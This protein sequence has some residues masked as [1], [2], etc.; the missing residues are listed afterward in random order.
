LRAELHEGDCLD[1]LP[2]VPDASVDAIITDPPYPMIDRP[3]GKLTEAEWWDLMVEGVIPQVRRILKPT[4]SAVFI[5]QPNSRKVGSMRGWLFEFQAW[6]CREWNMVQ[7]AW[8]WNISAMPMGGATEKGLMRPSLKACVWLGPA[9]CYREQDESLWDESLVNASNRLAGRYA[10]RS[11]P[12]C[13]RSESEQPRI[14]E[15]RMCLAASRR[16]GVTPF[17]VL[18]LGIGNS[19]SSAGANG[20]SAGTPDYLASWWTRYLVPKDVSSVVCDP[21]LGSGTMALAALAHGASFVG[22]D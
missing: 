6:A 11:T 12:S 22:G 19:V 16:G 13:K 1:W 17:N 14:D 15:A 3:Y 9:D 21:F 18:P 20:H 7:D 10:R 2:L 4:G 5:L 8:W